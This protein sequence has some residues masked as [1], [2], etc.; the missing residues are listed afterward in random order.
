MNVDM[1]CVLYCVSSLVRV[2]CVFLL[3]SHG[4]KSWDKHTY[5]SALLHAASQPAWEGRLVGGN[6]SV[7]GIYLVTLRIVS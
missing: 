6:V 2:R 4:R 7:A 5:R 3:T 1:I